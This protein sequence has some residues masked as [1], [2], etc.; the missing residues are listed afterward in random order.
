MFLLWLSTGEATLLRFKSL[1]FV[2][3]FGQRTPVILFFSDF[4]RDGDLSNLA[5]IGWF[6][7]ELPLLKCC[8][9]MGVINTLF[10]N[11]RTILKFLSSV[12]YVWEMTAIF[13]FM[14]S[15]SLL[16]VII[17]SKRNIDPSGPNFKCQRNGTRSWKLE[18]FLNARIQS[19]QSGCKVYDTMAFSA[20]YLHWFNCM[21]S[22][23]SLM[24]I[25]VLV[26]P[27]GR[28]SDFSLQTIP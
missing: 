22:Y 25:L 8:Q 14:P 10:S 16:C 19:H 23:L 15:V 21:L 9:Y 1:R 13:L 6:D 28:A 26:Q 3:S 2:P 11:L 5:D 27:L 17:H 20:W 4:F 7:M 18:L 12:V 24:I